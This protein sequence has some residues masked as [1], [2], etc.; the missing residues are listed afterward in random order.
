MRMPTIEINTIIHLVI[1]KKKRFSFNL[2]FVSFSFKF[3][4]KDAINV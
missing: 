2:K 1:Q 3:E 4:A